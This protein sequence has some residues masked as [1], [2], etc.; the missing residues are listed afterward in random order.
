MIGRERRTLAMSKKQRRESDTAELHDL[1]VELT[2]L[3]R[4]LIA[5]AKKVLVIFEGR[6]ASGEDAA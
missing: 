4:H 2:K 5:T 1:K 6:D 3:Q